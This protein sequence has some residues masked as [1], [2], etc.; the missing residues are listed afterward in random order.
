MRNSDTATTVLVI[1]DDKAVRESLEA[2]L[3]D[4]G[5]RALTCSDAETALSMLT[6]HEVDAAVVDIRL[7]GLNGEEFIKIARDRR[8]KMVFLVHTGSPDFEIHQDEKNAHDI[9]ITIIHKPMPD[10]ELLHSELMRMLRQ[11]RG[12]S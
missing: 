10:F 12:L 1:D 4:S 6:D 5:F 9:S 3:E 2:Y 8:P 7:P 11:R